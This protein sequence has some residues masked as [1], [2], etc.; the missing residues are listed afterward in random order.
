MSGE[1]PARKYIRERDASHVH[2]KLRPSES[3]HTAAYA[4]SAVSL[5]PQQQ[6]ARPTAL[7][8]ARWPRCDLYRI[9]AMPMVIE[10]AVDQLSVLPLVLSE[11]GGGPAA[12][13]T[14]RR[15]ATSAVV[16]GEHTRAAVAWCLGGAGTVSVREAAERRS[17]VRSRLAYGCASR[18]SSRRVLLHNRVPCQAG[19][20]GAPSHR[21]R[22]AGRAGQAVRS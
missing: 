22:T 11:L 7:L 4:I 10:E 8:G 16:R 2:R 13:A 14:H 19:G 5:R 20:V 9:A 17:A 18:R 1:A 3:N 6:S 15:R 12:T 21:Q